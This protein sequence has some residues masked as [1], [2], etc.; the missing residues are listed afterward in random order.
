MMDEIDREQLYNTA[1]KHWGA[2]TQ[3]D[4]L[5]EEMAELTQAILKARRHSDT[6]YTED[7]ME[8]LADVL[9]CLEQIETRMKKIPRA[10]K[11]HIVGDNGTNWDTVIE[12][13]E[14]K[15]GRL[16]GRLFDSLSQKYPGVGDHIEGW[17]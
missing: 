11:N 4:I 1:W 6:P 10:S 12:S 16:K 2:D 13:K 3:L 14:E 15:L 5:I 7:F 9:I 8:E 17:R